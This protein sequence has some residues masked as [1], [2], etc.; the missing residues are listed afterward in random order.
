MFTIKLE[1]HTEKMK[2]IRLLSAILCVLLASA[3][4][5]ARIWTAGKN[6][7]EAELVSV[8]SDGSKAVLRKADG[9]RLQ[10]SVSVLSKSDQNYIRQNASKPNAVSRPASQQSGQSPAANMGK[11]NS[12][13]SSRQA[14]IPAGTQPG[15][16]MY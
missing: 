3:A 2:T 4:C 8:S 7:V 16:R 10:V 15:Q 11:S 9:K 5:S 1:N 12:S 14:V 13:N 6:T